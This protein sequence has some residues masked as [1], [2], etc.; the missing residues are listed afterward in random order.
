MK[1]GNPPIRTGDIANLVSTNCKNI[2]KCY[3]FDILLV[4][5]V[6]IITATSHFKE[7]R[8]TF[9]MRLAKLYLDHL[10]KSYNC[11]SNHFHGKNAT[12]IVYKHFAQ[13]GRTKITQKSTVNN[14][15]S[16]NENFDH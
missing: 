4:T 6:L 14:S 5:R 3:C 7:Y 13:R 8:Y 16:K 2:A 9:Q 10:K 1:N 11:R 12:V 15:R